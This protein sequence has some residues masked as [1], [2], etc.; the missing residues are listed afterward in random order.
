MRCLHFYN[1]VSFW[2]ILDQCELKQELLFHS[3]PVNE[4]KDNHQKA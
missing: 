3:G 4:H 1:N 2:H